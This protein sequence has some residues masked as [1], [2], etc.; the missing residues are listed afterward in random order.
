MRR[1]KNTRH[2]FIAKHLKIVCCNINLISHIPFR[3]FLISCSCSSTAAPRRVKM[4]PACEFTPTAVTTIFP[5]PSI[6]CVPGTNNK[7]V[8][9]FLCSR[10]LRTCPT[11]RI[12]TVLDFKP[13]RFEIE[14]L[15]RKPPQNRTKLG[16][17]TPLSYYISMPPSRKMLQVCI[18]LR[19]DKFTANSPPLLHGCLRA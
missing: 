3:F 15:A 13:A 18:N 10:Y 2:K 6:T 14:R 19:Q 7:V 17:I 9:I 5:L 12:E 11:S 8:S 1:N 4:I 16:F